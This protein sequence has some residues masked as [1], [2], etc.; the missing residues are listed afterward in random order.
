MTSLQIASA[1]SNLVEDIV[2]VKIIKAHG[3]THALELKIMDVICPLPATPKKRGRPLGSKNKN[4]SD[5][6]PTPTAPIKKKRGRPKGSKG[7]K[8]KMTLFKVVKEVKEVT[9]PTKRG[10]RTGTKD[11]HTRKSKKSTTAAIIIQKR[12]RERQ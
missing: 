8:N 6:P 1:V 3:S 10:R 2:P 11:R 4:K 7:S 9:E 5:I 12:W